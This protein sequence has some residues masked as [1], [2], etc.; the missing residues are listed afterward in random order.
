MLNKIV[1]MSQPKAARTAGLLYL[2]NALFATLGV[3]A[4]MSIIVPTDAVTTASNIMNNEL[5]YLFGFMN[6]IGM[7]LTGVFLPLALYVVFKPVDQKNAILFVVL[8]VVTV[9]IMCFNLV[10]QYAALLVLGEADYLALFTSDQS[11]ALSMLFLD[12]E[13]IGYTIAKIFWGLWLLPLGYLVYKSEYIPKILGILLIISCFTY[14]LDFSIFF[15][16]PDIYEAV[17]MIIN[18]PTMFFELAFAFW[19]LIKGVNITN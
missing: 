6:N 8:M 15:L 3:F 5:L 14:L 16:L 13:E 18:L 10:N 9:P 11:T 1:N 17:S 12:L 2:L 19:L 4:S 7:L